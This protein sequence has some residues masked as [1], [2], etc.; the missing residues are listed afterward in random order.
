MEFAKGQ[1]PRT[2]ATCEI[3]KKY[4]YYRDLHGTN[5]RNALMTRGTRTNKV[6]CT[7]IVWVKIFQQVLPKKG[8]HK[9]FDGTKWERYVNIGNRIPQVN[10]M[11]EVEM[12]IT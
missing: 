4:K 11:V 12:T 7:R 9:A 2:D 1:T 8:I 3:I 5:M 6:R 10:Y